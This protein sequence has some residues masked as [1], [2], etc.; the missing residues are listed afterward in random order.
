MSSRDIVRKLGE[1]I[2]KG[3]NGS[4][5]TKTHQSAKYNLIVEKLQ[6]KVAIERRRGSEWPS[7]YYFL[8]NRKRIGKAVLS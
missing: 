6:N 3:I 4:T 7:C 8:I 2:L 5:R 1:L